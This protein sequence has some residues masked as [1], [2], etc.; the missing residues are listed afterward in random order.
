VSIDTRAH[1]RRVDFGDH[2]SYTLTLANLG[3][4]SATG[5]E[6]LDTLAAGMKFKSASVG[7]VEATGVVTCNLGTIAPGGSLI[8]KI[9]VRAHKAGAAIN[10]ASVSIGETDTDASNDSAQMSTFVRA[11]V[12]VSIHN[13]GQRINGRLRA[14]DT[15]CKPGH[16]KVVLFGAKKRSGAGKRI[17]AVR[18]NPRGRYGFRLHGEQARFFHTQAKHTAKCSMAESRTV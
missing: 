6:V 2:V 7:C 14:N 17:D 12:N 18:A 16:N 13:H 3:P 5:V 8:V 15:I 10:M 11:K 9:V 4:S 1:K